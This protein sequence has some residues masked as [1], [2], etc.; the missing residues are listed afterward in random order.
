MREYSG[1]RWQAKLS[2]KGAEGRSRSHS[3]TAEGCTHI[4]DLDAGGGGLLESTLVIVDNVFHYPSRSDACRMDHTSKNERGCLR[5]NTRH[6][7][8][9]ALATTSSSLQIILNM[10]GLMRFPSHFNDTN[11]IIGRSHDSSLNVD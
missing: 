6:Q 11:A 3:G 2:R 10:I 9:R 8:Q 1:D 5:P 7:N 4:G